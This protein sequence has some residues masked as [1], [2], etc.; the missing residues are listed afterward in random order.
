MSAGQLLQP[1]RRLRCQSHFMLDVTISICLLCFNAALDT[2][3]SRS[4]EAF[5]HLAPELLGRRHF[6]CS[7]PPDIF[8]VRL[9]CSQLDPSPLAQRFV[10]SEHLFD[11]E[12]C[13]PPIEQQVME[14]PNE[15]IDVIRHSD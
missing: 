10:E 9:H 5:E 12:R 7:Q 14:P 6:L 11:H 3:R 13:G 2:Q 15:V 4:T 1:L 8:A